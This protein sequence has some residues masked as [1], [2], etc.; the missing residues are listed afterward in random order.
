MEERGEWLHLVFRELGHC[1]AEH[2]AEDEE[3]E[4][5]SICACFYDVRGE[6]SFEDG[7]PVFGLFLAVF[8][9]SKFVVFCGLCW[10]VVEYFLEFC[11]WLTVDESW[12]D[13]V[14][15][16]E[17]EDDCG[18]GAEEVEAEGF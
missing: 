5:L 15:D 11:V 2:E 7:G 14:Y 18:E 3:A 12:L 13:E 4:E 8:C 10:S 17:S 1:D 6:H 9:E 16:D